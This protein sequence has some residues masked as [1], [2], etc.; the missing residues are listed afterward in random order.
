MSVSALDFLPTH[1]QFRSD[2]VIGYHR[3]SHRKAHLDF[4]SN[5]M[6]KRKVRQLAYSGYL[7]KGARSRLKQCAE[8]LSC[9]TPNRRMVHPVY[10]NWFKFRLAFVTLT[11]PVALDLEMEMDMSEKFVKPIV[12]TMIRRFGVKN[13][14]WKAELTKKGRLHLHLLVD[15]TIH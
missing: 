13:Y 3:I 2:R 6:S 9:V 12:Q 7:S 15:S 11:F 5:S 10:Q 4:L 1:C 14:V 8:I